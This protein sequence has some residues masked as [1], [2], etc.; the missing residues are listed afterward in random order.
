MLDGTVSGL[1]EG[2]PVLYSLRELGRAFLFCRSC[3]Q[4]HYL[5]GDSSPGIIYIQLGSRDSLNLGSELVKSE[6]EY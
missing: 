2:Y 4:C 6:I 1:L 3:K 5:T